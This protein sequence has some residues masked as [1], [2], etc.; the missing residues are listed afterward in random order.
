MNVFVRLY[1][2]CLCMRTAF[3]YHIPCK[4]VL[5]IVYLFLPPWFNLP[6]NWY[7]L[8]KNYLYTKRK[9]NNILCMKGGTHIQSMARF[10]EGFRR[11]VRNKFPATLTLHHSLYIFT[12]SI[13]HRQ[14]QHQQKST[15]H[16]FGNNRHTNTELGIA[17]HY[18]NLANKDCY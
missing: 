5:S 8:P 18:M 1:L 6:W 3:P 16:L 10:D 9:A 2:L 7:T 13:R 11:A 15:C 17:F 12:I 4:L 14:H